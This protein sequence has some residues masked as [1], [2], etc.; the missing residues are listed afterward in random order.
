MLSWLVHQSRYEKH[1]DAC[2]TTSTVPELVLS[3]LGL[4]LYSVAT[5]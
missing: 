4:T 2:V 1:T 5:R 3:C